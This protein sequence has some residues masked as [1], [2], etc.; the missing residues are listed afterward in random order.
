VGKGGLE[1]RFCETKRPGKKVRLFFRGKKGGRKK[2]EGG[3]R[4][5]SC[6]KKLKGATLLQSK[7]RIYSLMPHWR[8]DGKRSFNS[9]EKAEKLL[10]NKEKLISF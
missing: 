4:D 3:E 7:G 9:L 5:Q 1:C 10:S 2:E 6:V 8:K